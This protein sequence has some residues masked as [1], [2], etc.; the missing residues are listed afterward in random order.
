MSEIVL[1]RAIGDVEEMVG[2][3]C[4]RHRQIAVGVAARQ[5]QEF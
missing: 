2:A 4:C 3:I 1:G 5:G